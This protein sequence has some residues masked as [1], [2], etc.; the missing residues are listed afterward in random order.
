MTDSTDADP[1]SCRHCGEALEDASSR[2]V[3]SSIEDGHAVHRQFC[4]DECLEAWTE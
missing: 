4:D 3:V 2:R 1:A